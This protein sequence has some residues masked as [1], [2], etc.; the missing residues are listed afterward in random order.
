[1]KA[2]RYF[3]YGLL[4]LILLFGL[5][6]LFS[7]LADYKPKEHITLYESTQ[8][9]T[10]D[11]ANRL[12]LLTWNIG[13]AGLGKEMDF[14][15]DGGKKVRT[16]QKNTRRYLKGIGTFL[17]S[18]DSIQ[19]I[20][21]QE[22]DARSKRTYHINEVDFLA[23]LLKIPFHFFAINYKA[24]FVPVPPLE[25]MGKVKSGL[26]SFTKFN[27]V[28]VERWDFPGS[29]PWPKSLF[30]LDRCF[31]VEHFIV[32]NGKEL[33]VI[34]THNSAFDGGVLKK[35]EMEYLKNYVTSEYSKGNYVL[36][37]GDW[38][39]N[40]PGFDGSAFN[41]NS[42]YKNFVLTSIPEGYLPEDWSWAFDPSQ[43]TNRSLVKAYNPESTATTILDMFLT[44]PNIIPGIPKT[45]N[46]GFEN[47]DHQPVLFSISLQKQIRPDIFNK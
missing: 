38:N 31:M 22:V 29:Y 35:H 21:L 9:D 47:S 28:K 33:L 2:L 14:F 12:N 11:L 19:M 16:T 3:L 6:L 40:P 20:L 36:T 41:K 4:I 17:A 45:I 10:L 27:P 26:L 43:P 37:G 44:S 42:G 24:F 18:N 25:P 39:Q 23:K 34:N 46:L 15:Y 7:T 8:P 32:S 5:F 1:M 30:M 13:Y